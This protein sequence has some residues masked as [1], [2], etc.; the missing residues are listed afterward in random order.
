MN[1]TKQVRA[2]ALRT[3]TTTFTAQEVSIVV[4]LGAGACGPI[5][6]VVEGGVTGYEQMYLEDFRPRTESLAW[7]ACFGTAGRWD[8]L[9]ISSSEMRRVF[10]ELGIVIRDGRGALANDAAR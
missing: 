3:N 1:W 7:C 10:V 8:R 9:E 2:V 6:G 4:G 5:L